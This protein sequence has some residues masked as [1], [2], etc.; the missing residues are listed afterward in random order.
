MECVGPGIAASKQHPCS[1][2]WKRL[3]L[4]SQKESWSFSYSERKDKNCW[5]FPGHHSKRKSCFVLIVLYSLNELSH[6][7]SGVD[8]FI[9]LVQIIFWSFIIEW[10]QKA[11]KQ[12]IM[13]MSINSE[14]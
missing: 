2:E 6:L 8:V 12:D 11:I 4:T 5:V 1:Q 7:S 14:Y 10:L 3:I 13:E 9:V